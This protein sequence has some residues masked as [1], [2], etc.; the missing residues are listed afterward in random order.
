MSILQIRK[1]RLRE[2]K[3]LVHVTQRCKSEAGFKPNSVRTPEPELLTLRLGDS[4]LL[5]SGWFHLCC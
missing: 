4:C 2:V 3:S 1:L 5:A